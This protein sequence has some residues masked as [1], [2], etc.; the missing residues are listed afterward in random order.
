MVST[1]AARAGHS[2]PFSMLVSDSLDSSCPCQ[3]LHSPRKGALERFLRDVTAWISGFAV[4]NGEQRAN[5][6]ALDYEHGQ[7]VV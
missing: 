7:Q 6:E 5:E 2:S 1:K 4:E 3:S